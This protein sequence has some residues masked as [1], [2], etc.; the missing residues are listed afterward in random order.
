MQR[1]V[2]STSKTIMM[3][4]TTFASNA[5]C[6]QMQLSLVASRCN[7]AIDAQPTNGIP[8]YF[9]LCLHCV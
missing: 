3:L 4:E 7:N 1:S 5:Q 8:M 2:A 9:N 6:N